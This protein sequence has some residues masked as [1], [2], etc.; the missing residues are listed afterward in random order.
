MIVQDCGID[1]FIARRISS[2]SVI[3]GI[4]SLRMLAGSMLPGKSRGRQINNIP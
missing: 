2:L 3:S 4:G 1:G